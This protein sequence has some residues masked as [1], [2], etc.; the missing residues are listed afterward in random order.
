MSNVRPLSLK[1]KKKK[2]KFLNVEITFRTSECKCRSPQGWS[3][4]S[5]SIFKDLLGKQQLL[6]I[7][8]WSH[9]NGRIPLFESPHRIQYIKLLP[10]LGKVDHIFSTG[11]AI[12]ISNVDECQILQDQSTV[13]K[14]EYRSKRILSFMWLKEPSPLSQGN[15][16]T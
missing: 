6:T 4:H 14:I 12:L 5:A 1:K 11:K 10:S 9:I 16:S 15:T 8:R 7:L 2:K 3:S 13:K